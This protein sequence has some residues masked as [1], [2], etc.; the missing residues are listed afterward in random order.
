M[1]RE[2]EAVTCMGCPEGRQ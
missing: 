1:F 2:L